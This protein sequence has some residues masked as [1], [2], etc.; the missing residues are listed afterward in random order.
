MTLPSSSN[1]P[2]GGVWLNLRWSELRNNAVNTDGD[3]FFMTGK[4]S[5]FFVEPDVL[6]DWTT[7]RPLKTGISSG[8]ELRGL[9]GQQ[10]VQSSG[11][12]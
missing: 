10:T 5:L 12:V 4:A 11:H 2:R 6:S 1:Q 3:G 7:R 8:R 9:W